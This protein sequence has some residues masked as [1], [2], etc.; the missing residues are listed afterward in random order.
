ME[1]TEAGKWDHGLRQRPLT[2]VMMMVTAF[3]PAGSVIYV[4][5]FIDDPKVRKIAWLS[6]AGVTLV[7]DGC[8]FAV[9]RL[10][11]RGAIS[12]GAKRAARKLM[13]WTGLVFA[14]ASVLAILWPSVP[15][16]LRVKAG[17]V[18]C[19]VLSGWYYLKPM[20]KE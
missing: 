6:W 13:Y 2:M 1:M 18:L 19:G 17:V 5:V 20:L 3:L 4:A 15:L 10:E 9:W 7:L 11:E 16:A 12:A 14:G 8:L